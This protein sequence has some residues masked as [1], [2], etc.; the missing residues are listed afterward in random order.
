MRQKVC[1]MKSE[2][3]IYESIKDILD[4][5][6]DVNILEEQIDI[7]L[8]LEYF[9]FSRGLDKDIP[10]D[11]IL[12]EKEKLFESD[13]PPESKKELLVMLASTQE[14]EALRVIEKYTQKPDHDLKEWAVLAC[15]ESRMLLQS[16]FLGEDQVFIS[17]GLGG[18]GLK[19]R[20]FIVVVNKKGGSFSRFQKKV[21]RSEFDFM[22]KKNDSEIEESQFSENFCRIVAV[23]PLNVPVRELL[24]D[25]LREINLL[26]GLVDQ[27]FIVTNVKKMSNTE[28]EEFIRED[29]TKKAGGN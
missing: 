1:F 10:A 6:S 13:Y 18:K 27:N 21:I 23:V 20:Y 24:R 25:T 14:V 26:G 8:Q 29:E 17:T 7:D 11:E 16:K 5:Y 22:F 9:E 28:I 2:E 3:N 12:S 4:K 19:L 15:Q